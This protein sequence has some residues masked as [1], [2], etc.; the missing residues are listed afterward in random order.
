MLEGVN[1]FEGTPCIFMVRFVESE[2]VSGSLVV[3]ANEN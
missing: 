2:G 1:G 3:N